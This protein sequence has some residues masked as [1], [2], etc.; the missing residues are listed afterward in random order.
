M[1][2]SP[3]TT[4]GDLLPEGMV[5][6]SSSQKLRNPVT[7]STPIAVT[8]TPNSRYT[9]ED[10]TPFFPKVPAL[11]LSYRNKDVP[12]FQA[13]VTYLKNGGSVLCIA[14]PHLMA[15]QE[16]CRLLFKS[17]ADEY[18]ALDVSN[19]GG[20]YQQQ[21]EQ[22]RNDVKVESCKNSGGDDNKEN[23]NEASDVLPIVTKPVSTPPSVVNTTTKSANTPTTTSTKAYVMG[24]QALESHATSALPKGWKSSRFEKRNWRYVPSILGRGIGNTALAGMPVT[25]AYYVSASR[26]EA[27]KAEAT[28]SIQAISA[29]NGATAKHPWIST[30]DALVAR[31]RQAIAQSIPGKGG[32]KE[33][34]LVI[35]LRKRM[36]PA[37]PAEALGNCSWTVAVGSDYTTNEPD[38]GV[39]AAEIRAAILELDNNATCHTSSPSTPDSDTTT[40]TTTTT[41]MKA[42]HARSGSYTNITNR[43]ICN[44][45]RWMINNT[46]PGG[47]KMPVVFQNFSDMVRTCGPILVSHWNWGGSEY[48]DLSFGGGSECTPVWH[49][50]TFPKL[51][52]CVF[53]VPAP[54]GGAL[55]HVTLHKKMA[56]R[57]KAKCPAL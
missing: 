8:G 12:L 46:R 10:M 11:I 47:A 43:D 31:L 6:T 20:D 4:L 14:V 50:P 49:Q 26:L 35:D 53:I 56:D 19:I 25:V 30:N 40:T 37:L 45:L 23:D 9:P 41:P 28:K 2:K 18:T 13:Q 51:P 36:E 39:L 17:W 48:K 7:T 16:T 32:K 1:A 15:D 24:G 55:V 21:R 27:L 52:N 34:Q 29:N 22:G 54:C 5:A 3:D 44:E 38:L 33:L 57:L 42:K